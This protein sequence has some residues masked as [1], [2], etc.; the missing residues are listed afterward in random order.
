MKKPRHLAMSGI[1]S[2]DRDRNALGLD[3]RLLGDLD[4]EHAIG[5]AR[6]DR[7]RLRGIRQGKAA[8]ECACEALNVFETVAV[9]AL[10]RRSHSTNCQQAILGGDFKGTPAITTTGGRRQVSVR[11][12]RP[13]LQAGLCIGPSL[14]RS[15]SFRASR[16]RPSTS[17]VRAPCIAS[18][19]ARLQKSGSPS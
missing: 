5:I 8:L 19:R 11:A 15:P 3:S 10:S 18:S 6:L 4:L 17:D 9:R 16:G 12:S 1:R 2:I 14:G 13:E 7:V